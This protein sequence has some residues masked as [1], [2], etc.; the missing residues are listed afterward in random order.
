MQASLTKPFFFFFK[1]ELDEPARLALGELELGSL[2]E[3]SFVS[4][5]KFKF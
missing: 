2:K 5:A 3:F 1:F 4:R